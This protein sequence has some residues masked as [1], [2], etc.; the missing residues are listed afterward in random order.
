MKKSNNK[1]RI[2]SIIVMACVL[3]GM[4]DGLWQPGY[5]IKSLLKITLFLM[6]PLLYAKYEKNISFKYLFRFDRLHFIKA[7][8]MGLLVFIFILVMY[9]IIDP[10]FD[11]SSVTVSLEKELGVTKN[12]FLLVAIYISFANA[13]LEEFFFRGFAFLELKK[14]TSRISALTISAGA[15]ALYH[16]FMMV[17]WFS[18]SLFILLLIGLFVGGL[19]FN[20]INERSNNIYS[21]WM[22]HMFANF[23]INAVGFMLYN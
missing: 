21:S 14:W 12:N 6:L 3:M 9:N 2:I 18:L 20:L 5:L 19:M 4:V 10:Y 1:I 16:V 15:F 8:G 13:L 7:L 11:F 22:V 17:N 23:A